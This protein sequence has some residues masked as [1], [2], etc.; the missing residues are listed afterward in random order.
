VF[1]QGLLTGIGAAIISYSHP[2]ELLLQQ[3]L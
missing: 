1:I 3:L 2:I